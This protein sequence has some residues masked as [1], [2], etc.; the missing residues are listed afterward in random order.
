MKQ[1][2]LLES[3]GF[4]GS[5]EVSYGQIGAVTARKV[6]VQAGAWRNERHSNI[7]TGV[8]LST[9]MARISK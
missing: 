3:S 6:G 7:P 9:G 8:V 5:R 1:K 4:G 2:K